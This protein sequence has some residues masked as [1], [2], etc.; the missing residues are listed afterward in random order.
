MLLEC[1]SHHCELNPCGISEGTAQVDCLAGIGQHLWLHLHPLT[2][3]SWEKQKKD[4]LMS[5]VSFLPKLEE[6]SRERQRRNRVGS[7]TKLQSLLMINEDSVEV[8]GATTEDSI[9]EPK[10][11]GQESGI[12]L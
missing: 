2:R 3:R 1:V 8:S 6:G 9:G 4:T 7:G 12:S 10:Q 11:V 5:G